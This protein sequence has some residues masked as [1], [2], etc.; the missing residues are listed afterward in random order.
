M[1]SY[2]EREIWDVYFLIDTTK[3]VDIETQKH[4]KI[5]LSKIIQK[6]L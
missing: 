5:V 1:L 2:R 4:Y 3:S 6:Y